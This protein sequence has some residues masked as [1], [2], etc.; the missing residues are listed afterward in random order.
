MFPDSPLHLFSV[1]NFFSLYCMYLVFAFKCS[2]PKKSNKLL[3]GNGIKKN[4]GIY[5]MFLI[6]SPRSQKFHKCL[7]FEILLFDLFCSNGK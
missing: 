3:T 6:L 2:K 5:M 4:K 1:L 7:I